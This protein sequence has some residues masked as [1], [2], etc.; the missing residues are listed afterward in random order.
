MRN[1]GVTKVWGRFIY[2]VHIGF[3]AMEREL[4]W[5]LLWNSIFSIVSKQCICRR[6]AGSGELI[7]STSK[8]RNRPF[9]INSNIVIKSRTTKLR[10]IYFNSAFKQ[11]LLLAVVEERSLSLFYIYVRL[12]TLFT[13][14]S[15]ML[16]W[17]REITSLTFYWLWLNQHRIFLLPLSLLHTAIKLIFII[18]IN[19]CH[20]FLPSLLYVWYWWLG[21]NTCWFCTTLNDGQLYNFNV[22]KVDNIC[23]L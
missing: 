4:T 11:L 3:Y 12:F 20:T 23:C 15:S 5:K 19:W 22:L 17:I 14:S 7:S 18:F 9:L 1:E 21:V 6:R 2:L 16:R 8:L 13:L 10:H